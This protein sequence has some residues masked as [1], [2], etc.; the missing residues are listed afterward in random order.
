MKTVITKELGIV[1]N[2]LVTLVR[3]V[4][5]VGE[6]SSFEIEIKRFEKEPRCFDLCSSCVYGRLE[7]IEPKGCEDLKNMRSIHMR[8]GKGENVF[9]EDDCKNYTEYRCIM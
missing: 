9:E 5:L 8:C 1:N 7:K 4:R 6:N 2:R 3:H